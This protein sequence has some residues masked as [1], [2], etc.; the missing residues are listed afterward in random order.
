MIT[1]KLNMLP[2][3]AVRVYIASDMR[4]VYGVQ[5]A[6]SR[7]INYCLQLFI[8]MMKWRTPRR[9]V[10]TISAILSLSYIKYNE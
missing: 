1:I 10:N 6:R 2:P 3:R 4:S 5:F 9:L 7:F 8:S